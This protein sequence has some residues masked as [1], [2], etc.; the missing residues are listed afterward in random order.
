MFNFKWFVRRCL[1]FSLMTVLVFTTVYVPAQSAFAASANV[2]IPTFKVTLNGK[3]IDNTLRKYPLIVYREI[4]YVP[5]TW[6][7]C[8]FLGLESNWNSKSG[9]TIS[10]TGV[11]G[12]Y[13]D[14]NVTSP[15]RASYSAQT[16]S[17]AITVNGKSINNAAETYPLLIFRDITY[18]PLTWRFA[19]DEFGWQYAYTAA[20]GL[21]IN[22]SAAESGS[23]NTSSSNT[24]NVPGSGSGSN[25]GNVPGSGG[26]GS[27]SGSGTGSAGQ[28]APDSKTLNIPI[29]TRGDYIGAC[30]VAG[31][32]VYYEGAGGKIY[33]APLTNLS[34]SKVVYQLPKDTLQVD[35]YVQAGLRTQ[36]E[37]AW[38]YYHVGS[39]TMGTNYMFRLKTDGVEDFSYFTYETADKLISIEQAGTWAQVG[40]LKI[41]S[42]SDTAF[43]QAGD[44]ELTYSNTGVGS[45]PRLIGNTLYTFASKDMTTP[46]Y[47]Y[48]IDLLSGA[49]TKL[50]EE[51]IWANR[52]SIDGNNIYF[53]GEDG[54]ARQ[55]NLDGTNVKILSQQQA[56]GIGAIGGE[57]YLFHDG[58]NT[59][60]IRLSDGKII[61]QGQHPTEIRPVVSDIDKQTAYL[62]VSFDM[63][64]GGYRTIILNSAGNVVYQSGDV[65]DRI[66]IG[67]NTLYYIN[68]VN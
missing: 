3:L 16:A 25:S 2:T 15:N 52:F 49:S 33:S 1:V 51:S 64:P 56:R 28:A 24:G 55:M 7:D 13:Y 59:P 8:R 36:N 65:K 18:F 37:R 32:Y 46:R 12:G 29:A 38:L 39:A 4:T 30:A 17:F 5:M 6:Y 42:P 14:D 27:P 60:L 21:V 68:S 20:G 57:V 62:W 22:S 44:R 41:K 10:K 67:G 26:T 48:A 31:A 45:D 43:R 11:T 47:L 34:A 54:L 23:G 50:F 53:I 40:N 66:V 9:L 19:V 61:N 58:N 35:Q 63:I